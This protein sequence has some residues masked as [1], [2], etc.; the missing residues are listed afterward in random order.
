MTGKSTELAALTHTEIGRLLT[1][2]EA[3]I[4]AKDWPAASALL[5]TVLGYEPTHAEATA[6]LQFVR[7]QASG[8]P[9]RIHGGTH[10]EIHIGRGAVIG[11]VLLV[12][13]GAAGAM[14]LGV[15]AGS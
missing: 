4:A 5:T 9:S 1:A 14:A 12:V 6:R 8:R 13:L 11:L 3:A 10:D 7:A 15:W 2:A